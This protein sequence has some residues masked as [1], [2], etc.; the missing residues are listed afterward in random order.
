M[1]FQDVCLEALTYVTPPE[2]WSSEKI[3]QLLAPL[4]KRLKLPLGRLEHMT[5][6]RE[7]RFWA[8]PR[9][10]SEIAAEAGMKLFRGFR[11]QAGKVPGVD[12]LIHCGV[13]RDRMEP[14]TA[15]YVHRQLK[16]DHRTSFMDVS[17]ACLGFANAVV[18][19]AGLIQAGQ[20][21]RCLVVAG[22]DGRPLLDRTIRALLDDSHNRRSIKSL[23]AN[24]TIG[25]G[26]VAASLCRESLCA[27]SRPLGQ[28]RA[29][30]TASDSRSN[31]LCQGDLAE[32]GGMQMATNSEALLEAGL[33]LA[34]QTWQKF[35]EETGWTV[36]TPDLVVTHQVG[37][38]HRL[39]LYQGLNMPI[40]KDYSTFAEFGNVGSVS[41]PLTLARAAEAGRLPANGKVALMGIGSGLSAMVMGLET[42]A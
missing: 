28:I 17:N 8:A 7:R 6:I 40:D 34:R 10:A 19:A 5:G 42:P 38:R 41:L 2:R 20:I 21:D 16:L 24:L 25:A 9:M 39:G 12:M 18:L 31:H 14:A 29:A 15:A 33:R 35:Q 4:Y 30:V 13:C 23:F 3:E 11:E 27:V 32:E 26:G 37:Q 36:D 22:E 1:K